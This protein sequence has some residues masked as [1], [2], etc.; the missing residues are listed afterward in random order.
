MRNYVTV[1]LAVFF[2]ISSCKPKEK[3]EPKKFISVLSLIEKQVAHIDTSLYSIRKYVIH[4]SLHIDSSYVNRENFR[5]VAKEFLEI[6]DLSDP[7]VAKRYKEETRY[8]ALTNWVI[9]SYIPVNPKKED[10]QKQEII[11]IPNVATGDKVNNII[12][13]RLISNK[14]GYLSKKMYWQTDK[15]FLI[16]TTSQ[17]PGEPEIVTTTKVIW[18]EYSL[19]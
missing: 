10:I 12:I 17:K 14:N 11:V 19:Q 18:D 16:T 1:M 9:V 6:P 13:E 15:N 4:D 2:L 7:K 8:D 5:E 3:E